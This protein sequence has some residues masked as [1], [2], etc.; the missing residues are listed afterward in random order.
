M[1]DTSIIQ[2]S[3]ALRDSVSPSKDELHKGVLPNSESQVWERL[4]VLSKE[5]HRPWPFLGPAPKVTGDV[6]TPPSVCTNSPNLCEYVWD[7]HNSKR[8]TTQQHVSWVSVSDPVRTLPHGQFDREELKQTRRQNDSLT[9]HS[10]PC[11]A[12]RPVCT[13]RRLHKAASARSILLLFYIKVKS[14]NR[15]RLRKGL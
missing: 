15:L 12:A 3:I 10:M 4:T 9:F 5:N 2:Y 1:E 6:Q 11:N 14:L 7:N 13:E 8:A